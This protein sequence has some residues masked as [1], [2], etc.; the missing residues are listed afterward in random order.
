MNSTSKD[1]TLVLGATG[2]TGSRVAERLSAHGASVRT[3]A[4]SGA[5]AR[6]DWDDRATW[7]QALRGATRL[8]L[9][10]PTLRVDF[11][12]QVGRFLDQAERAGVGHV[13][14]LSAYGMEH[15]P[16]QVALRAVELD[17]AARRSLTSTVI[18]PAWFMEDFSET[19]LQPVNDEIAVPAGDGAE[20]YV[21]VEDIASVAAVTLADPGRHAGRAYA[22]TGPQVLTMAEAAGLISEAV[23]RTISYRD[24]DREQ[25]ITAMIGAGVPAEYAAVLRPLTVTMASGNGARPNDDVLDVTGA[26]PIT[27]AEFAAATASAW[28]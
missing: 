20:A 5:D 8:Y 24:T 3:A 25:W 10:P 17:L 27:F 4:R 21:S 6:F 12:G 13:T 16:A 1:Q 23:G 7:E 9:V 15:A 28:K 18:R 19:F 14:Y 22:P 26:A 2:K 11:A